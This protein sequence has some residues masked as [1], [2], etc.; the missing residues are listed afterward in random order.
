MPLAERSEREEVKA[1]SPKS[2]DLAAAMKQPEREEGGGRF[3]KGAFLIFP[4][5]K[6][7]KER[8]RERGTGEKKAPIQRGESYGNGLKVE[9]K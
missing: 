7:E 4:G 5:R 2:L 8:P 1:E 3:P 9:L 6:R